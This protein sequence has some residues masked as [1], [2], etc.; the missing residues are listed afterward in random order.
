MREVTTGISPVR[1]P[2]TA[3]AQL[4]ALHAAVSTTCTVAKASIKYR[5]FI[6]N[7]WMI[8]D[9]RSTSGNA[10]TQFFQQGLFYFSENRGDTETLIGQAAWLEN[11]SRMED[12]HRRKCNM[13]RAQEDKTL[14]YT[15]NCNQFYFQVQ[16]I[17]PFCENI[18]RSRYINVS[19]WY[20]RYGVTFQLT[21]GM[22]YGDRGIKYREYSALGL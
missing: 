22:F 17:T 8:G 2:V 14:T 6:M 7:N 15:N 13:I 21:C 1:V 9:V 16:Q 19:A 18:G 20:C 10:E 11:S 12:S 5:N 3:L 4:L